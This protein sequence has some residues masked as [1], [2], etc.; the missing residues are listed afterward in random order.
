MPTMAG[1]AAINYWTFFSFNVVGRLM[2]TFGFT[3]M[4]Y[5]LGAL[6]PDVDR[7]LLPIVLVIIVVSLLPFVFHIYQEHKSNRP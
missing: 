4:G 7:S 3:I 6:I 1:I 5:S 2:W